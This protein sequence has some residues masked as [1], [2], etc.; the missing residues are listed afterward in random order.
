MHARRLQPEL[1]DDPSLDPAEHARALAGLR[2]INTV[3]AAWRSFLPTLRDVARRIAPRPVGLLDV[4]TGS[5]DVPIRLVEQGR[6]EGL[7]LELTLSDISAQALAIASAR[8]TRVGLVCRT[9]P[10]DVVR[11]GLA[12][13]DTSMDVVTCSLFMHHLDE[14]GVV[15]ALRECARVA[16]HHVLVL[17]LRR[18]RA[19]LWSA[20]L[21]P[22]LVTRSRVVHVD[23]VRSVEG[24]FTPGELRELASRAGLV[25]A[26]VRPVWPF[27]MLLEWS[28]S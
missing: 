21:V 5:G 25:G 6:R 17:D 13:S 3:S 22:R 9:I 2:R 8:A 7:A 27:R 14:T 10:G 18:E 4:A 19:H 20:R 11:E 26:R 23:A 24:A 28:R 12:L 16:R 15:R 1:M